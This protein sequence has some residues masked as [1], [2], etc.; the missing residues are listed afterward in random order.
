MDGSWMAF[1]FFSCL[2][3]HPSVGENVHAFRVHEPFYIQ[4]HPL[5]FFHAILH[6]RLEKFLMLGFY[7]IYTLLPFHTLSL[8]QCQQLLINA[9]VFL[10]KCRIIQYSIT[11]SEEKYLRKTRVYSTKNK[12]K[13]SHER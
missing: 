5:Y 11:T 9:N 1:L 4:N 6:P 2:N 3:Y 12:E 8:L 10:T 13:K 7:Y